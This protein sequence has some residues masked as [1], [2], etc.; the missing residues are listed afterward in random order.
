[1]K[2]TW[3]PLASEDNIK[4]FLIPDCPLIYVHGLLVNTA[5]CMRT[6][7]HF[8]PSQVE[9]DCVPIV[10][11]KQAV[12]ISL[13]LEPHINHKRCLSCRQGVE[14]AWRPTSRNS[15]LVYLT[16]P[17][18]HKRLPRPPGPHREMDLRGEV[19]KHPDHQADMPAP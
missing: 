1:M 2:V 7:V 5:D 19:R 15:T 16:D 8:F 9:S 18:D 13:T 12:L 6:R 11:Q 10:G 14:A 17:L 3:V 4:G